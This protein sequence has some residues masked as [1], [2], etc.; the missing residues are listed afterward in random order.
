MVPLLLFGLVGMVWVV[1]EGQEVGL[2][3]GVEEEEVIVRDIRGGEG[4]LLSD[5]ID[6]Q[7]LS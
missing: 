1:W 5:I 4:E 2:Y 3:G 6:H 7:N